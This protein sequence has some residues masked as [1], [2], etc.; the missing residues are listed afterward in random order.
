VADVTVKRIDEMD[1]LFD[2]MFVRARA[3]LGVTS[4]GMQVINLPAGWNDYPEHA[5]ADSPY[6]VANDGQEEVYLALQGSAT[7]VAGEETHRLEPGVMV[8]V[9]P[10]QTRRIVTEAE[11]VQILALGGTPGAVYSAA[12][13]T[14]VGA[15]PPPAPAR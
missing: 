9:G 1:S 11:P 7:L 2:G 15:P 10:A 12:P 8:R 14:E 13:F 6:E 4:W 3:E 5:H